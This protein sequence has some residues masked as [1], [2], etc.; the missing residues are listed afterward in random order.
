MV[1]ARGSQIRLLI[2]AEADPLEA[3]RLTVE[4]QR[5]A[6]TSRVSLPGAEAYITPT[7]GESNVPTHEPAARRRQPVFVTVSVGKRDLSDVGVGDR[8]PVGAEQVSRRGSGGDPNLADWVD[9]VVGLGLS[10]EPA[11][12]GTAGGWRCSLHAPYLSGRR[13]RW[14]LGLNAAQV[15]CV[16]KVAPVSRKA[17]ER[18][19]QD[20]RH[21]GA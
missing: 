14:F 12:R 3:R 10:T 2:G 1:V 16:V 8:P 17:G 5:P 4:S 7:D 15:F 13:R 9:R 11:S 18:I 6:V 19:V 21:S 20:I